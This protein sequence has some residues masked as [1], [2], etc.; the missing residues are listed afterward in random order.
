[1]AHSEITVKPA[2]KASKTSGPSFGTH[3]PLMSSAFDTS[4]W[5]AAA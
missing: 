3:M 5:L 4:A 2:A 1:M